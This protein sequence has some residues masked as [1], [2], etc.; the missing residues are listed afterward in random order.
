MST[1]ELAIA[2]DWDE[3]S[4]MQWWR[5]VPTWMWMTATA[6]AVGALIALS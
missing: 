1:H 3:E 5:T 6:F 2:H 4:L